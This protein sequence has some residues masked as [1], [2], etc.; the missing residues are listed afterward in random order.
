M[1]EY[2]LYNCYST[3][4]GHRI[5][6]F[7]S[8]LNVEAVYNLDP[9]GHCDCPASTR[10][11]CKHRKMMPIFV[12]A[13]AVNSDRF[14]C[15]ETQ[16]WHKPVALGNEPPMK[17]KLDLF[18]EALSG[19]TEVDVGAYN[20]SVQP[21]LAGSVDWKAETA[22]TA[23]APKVEIIDEATAITPKMWETATAVAPQP[24][25]PRET[26]QQIVAEQIKPIRRI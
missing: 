6:K 3:P 11:S 26:A 7:D 13:G 1:T 14:L 12:K 20:E 23:I 22:A 2:N 18:N 16:T 24:C 5:V 15:Y 4:T 8:L 10:P 25:K 21:N 19:A 17:E 9:L